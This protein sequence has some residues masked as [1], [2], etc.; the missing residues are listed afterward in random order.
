MYNP[1]RFDRLLSAT[2][3]T[4][5]LYKEKGW[6]VS[7]LFCAGM[8]R[9]DLLTQKENNGHIFVFFTWRNS[10]S[11]QQN[12]IDKYVLRIVQLLKKIR[13]ALPNTPIDIALHHE[14]LRKGVVAPNLESLNIN[15]I[16]TSEVSRAI[17]T[18]GLLITDY[19]SVCW[20]F[21]YMDKPLI[22][23]RFDSDDISLVQ[24]DQEATLSAMEEDRKLYNCLYKEQEVLDKVVQY[25]QNQF[26]IEPEIK[27]KNKNIFWP[28]RNNCANLYNL[29][30]GKK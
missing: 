14:C 20:D 22:F 8:P 17:R 30:Q 29:I 23:Y 26:Q 7:N 3:L 4:Y 16:P 19:S 27:E 21:M 13:Q 18:A 5:E 6:N 10:F 25:V 2:R 24:S 12:A 15:L 11:I 1:E 28:D 9:W